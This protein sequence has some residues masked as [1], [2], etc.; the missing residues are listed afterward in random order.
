[1]AIEDKA[2]ELGNLFCPFFVKA[3]ELNLGIVMLGGLLGGMLQ[4][5]YARLNPDKPNPTSGNSAWSALLG[6]AAAGISIYVVANSET[7]D[8]VRLLFFALLCGLAFPAVLTSAVDS[9]SKR[10]QD[11]AREVA[12]AAKQAKS[13]DIVQ[14]AQAADHLKNTLASN[15]SD[16]IGSKGLSVVEATAQIAVQNIAETATTNPESTAEVI[17]QL[18]QVGAV[19]RTAGYPG[20]VQVAAD[21][22]NKLAD[23]QTDDA[24]KTIAQDAAKQLGSSD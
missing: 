22:L 12:Q 16:A 11:A 17:N 18:Q 5:V 19:A 14:T 8:P 9:V 20:T 23:A 21:E 7:D 4:P 3:S 10:T 1:M 6:V 15:P 24:M 13:D 2:C